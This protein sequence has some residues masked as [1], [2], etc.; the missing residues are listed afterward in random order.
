MC[1]TVALTVQKT[2]NIL[3]VFASKGVCFDL[4]PF[5]PIANVTGNPAMSVPL[6]WNDA[7]L[8]IGGHFVG[9]FGDEVTLLRLASQLEKARPWAF[10]HPLISAWNSPGTL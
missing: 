9:R 5:T 2:Y 1:S 4:I 6:H 10:R 3:K 7:R 8:P